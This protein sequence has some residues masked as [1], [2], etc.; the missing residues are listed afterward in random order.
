MNPK[1]THSV[2]EHALAEHLVAP[3]LAYVKVDAFSEGDRPLTYRQ[4]IDRFDVG[5]SVRRLGRVLDAAERIL[6]R[7]G[8]PEVAAAGITAY[9]VNGGSGQPGYGWFEV[10]NM[11]A[12]DA[13]EEARAYVRR[14]TLGDD[15]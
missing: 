2:N 1:F 13:R 4:A 9:V 3:L 5:T 12:E 7:E 11:N 10:W 8:W 15:E 14:L 6:A